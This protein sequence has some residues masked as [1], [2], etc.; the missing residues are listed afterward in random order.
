MTIFAALL[1]VVCAMNVVV[2]GGL[3]GFWV[4]VSWAALGIGVVVLDQWW[5][6]M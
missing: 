4:G 6:R 5:R 1:V 3:Y 2:Y